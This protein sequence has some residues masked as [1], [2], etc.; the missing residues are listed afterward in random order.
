MSKI[1]DISELTEHKEQALSVIEKFLDGLI[2]GS[3]EGEKDVASSRKKAD[4]ICYWLKDYINFLSSEKDFDSKKLKRY[5]RGDVVK[6]HLGFRIG[7]EEG[8]L[9]YAVVLDTNNSL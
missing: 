7:S 2:N 6:V 9:H 5:K 1:K 8:G 3:E 4:L